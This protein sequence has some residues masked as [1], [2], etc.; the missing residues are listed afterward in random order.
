MPFCFVV[1]VS[2]S[3]VHSLSLYYFNKNK[4]YLALQQNLYAYRQVTSKMLR[5]SVS[6]CSLA[7][8][9]IRLFHT[10]PLSD[11][12]QQG[13]SYKKAEMG[14]FRGFPNTSNPYF[15]HLFCGLK[16][17]MSL[18]I[19]NTNTSLKWNKMFRRQNQMESKRDIF[20]PRRWVL[21]EL[22]NRR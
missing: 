9:R 8:V 10:A 11:C 5:S 17:F 18:K 19:L 3:S 2:E 6:Q 15:E 21:Y 1:K 4:K 20:K 13:A 12:Y 16:L 22:R 14:W 7:Q